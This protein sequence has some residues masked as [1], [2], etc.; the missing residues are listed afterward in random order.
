MNSVLTSPAPWSRRA[1]ATLVRAAGPKAADQQAGGDPVGRV[2]S[3]SI[4]SHCSAIRL[5]LTRC[6]PPP[7]WGSPG[8]IVGESGPLVGVA[9]GFNSS[10]LPEPRVA[11]A[12]TRPG[13]HRTVRTLVVYGSSGRRVMT[14]AA[15]RLIDLESSP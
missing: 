3:L 13:S 14:P 9:Q 8:I 12:V 1:S 11:G 10:A 5:G 6:R 2:A 15:G 7:L 4:S